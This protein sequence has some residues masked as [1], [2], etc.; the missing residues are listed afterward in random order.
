MLAV[1]TPENEGLVSRELM[2]R[3]GPTDVLAVISRAHLVDFEAMTDLVLEGRFRAA[4][5]VFPAEPFDPGHRIRRAPGAV[6][7]AHR[8]GALPEALLE[9][10]RMVIDDLE[11]ALAGGAPARMQYATPEMI[12]GLRGVS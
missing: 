9:I 12:E 7:S 3:L 11:T 4:T 5:D 6:L 8:A 10:G 1:P 2:E